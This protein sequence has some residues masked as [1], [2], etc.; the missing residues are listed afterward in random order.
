MH[1][2]APAPDTARDHT[3]RLASAAEAY[4]A[5]TAAYA[6]AAAARKAA[7]QTARADRVKYREI[8]AA[9]N[10]SINRAYTL[11]NDGAA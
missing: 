5:G 8:A 7:A 1:L 4:A 9:L 3:A 10:V 6:A 11:V 2:T